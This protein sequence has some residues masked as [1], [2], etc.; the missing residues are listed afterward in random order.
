[1]CGACRVTTGD[2]NKFSFFDGPEF[3]VD[4]VDFDEFLKRLITYRFKQ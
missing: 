3:E 1:M 2:K 4:I